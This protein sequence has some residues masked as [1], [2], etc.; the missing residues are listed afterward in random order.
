MRDFIR[1]SIRIASTNF[2]LTL[3]ALHL[4]MLFALHGWLEL[5]YVTIAVFAFLLFLFT[6]RL[7]VPT[8]RR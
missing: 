5:G 3:L 8:V 1:T 6:V 2:V 4:G 7:L